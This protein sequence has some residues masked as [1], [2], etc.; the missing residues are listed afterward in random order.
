MNDQ[1]REQIA[2]WVEQQID[3]ALSAEE[4]EQLQRMLL[5]RPDARSLYLDLMHQN[6]HLQ[7]QRQQLATA[8]TTWITDSEESLRGP[9]AAIRKA[10]WLTVLATLAASLL[11]FAWWN[12]QS[13]RLPHVVG[14]IA[15]IVD[16]SDAHWGDCTL[17]TAIGSRLAGGRL[18]I[19]R[20]LATIRF[21]SGAEVT[22]ESPAEI[23]LVSALSGRLL[24]GTAVVEVPESAHGFTLATPTAV[25][26][27]YGTA[28]S[29]TVDQS[30]Q[31]SSIEVIDGEVEVQHVGS[32]VARRLTQNQRVVAS[33]RGL[34]DSAASSDEADLRDSERSLS[35]SGIVHRI[36]TADGH[37]RDASITLG[38]LANA[39][40]K[41]RPDLILI[42]NPLDGFESFSRKGYFAFDLGALTGEPIAGAKFALT[43]SPSGLGYAS[44]VGDCEFVVYGLTD[45]AGDNWSPRELDWQSAPGNSPGPSAVDPA[46][47]VE[48][49]RFTV[50]RGRQHGQVAVEGSALVEF[51]KS[52]T[53]GIVTLI[54]VRLTP[55]HT[56]GGLV[57]GFANRQNAV[58]AP[59]ALLIQTA[60][61][62]SAN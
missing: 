13:A 17:P 51:L 56:S 35:K 41:S 52:D 45:E 34:S 21:A 9:S 53:N 14:E 20:G 47:V 33:T 27:D 8:S 12:L 6:A 31:A 11:L 10:T 25:A 49:G 15:Q 30:S 32:Q 48:V 19:E 28:F 36:T 40:A 54:V 61:A 29:V 1:D 62:S 46:R 24:S 58:A 59:P 57:H 23:E 7:L 37:G 39:A 18:K 55:E 26:I 22:L 4:F 50:Q 60:T 5:D 44:R 38:P 42:K 16:S 43:L 3:D 2:L